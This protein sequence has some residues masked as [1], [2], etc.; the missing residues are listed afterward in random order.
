MDKV[1]KVGK[2]KYAANYYS[3]LRKSDKSADKGRNEWRPNYS[4]G[5]SSSAAG[6]CARCSGGGAVEEQSVRSGCELKFMKWTGAP[7]KR[8]GQQL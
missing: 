8:D 6:K 5:K 3:W 1:S 7:V 2:V 4:R